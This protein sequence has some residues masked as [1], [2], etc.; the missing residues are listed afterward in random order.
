MLEKLAG[1][2]DPYHYVVLYFMPY[3]KLVAHTWNPS[4]S[5]GRDQEDR[6]L[7]PAWANNSRDPILKKPNTKK[8]LMEWLKVK[9][10]SSNPDTAK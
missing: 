9:A 2:H 6:S 10:L 8:G 5:G 1:V 7:K 3:E 4:Y